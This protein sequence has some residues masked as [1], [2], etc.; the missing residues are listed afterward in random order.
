MIRGLARDWKVGVV[1]FVKSGNWNVGEEKIGRQLE[2]R[3]CGEQEFVLE[4][5]T[6]QK[7][8]EI[9]S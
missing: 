3:V 8:H 2:V 7:I 6:R 4:N 1:Q 9:I 5:L